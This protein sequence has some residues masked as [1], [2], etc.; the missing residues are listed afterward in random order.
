[1]EEVQTWFTDACEYYEA[2][3]VE[4]CVECVVAAEALLLDVIASTM[5]EPS[6]L[7]VL[8][9][10]YVSLLCLHARCLFELSPGTALSLLL[11]ARRIHS[12]HA[13]VYV[14]LGAFFEYHRLFSSAQECFARATAITNDQHCVSSRWF[15]V[16]F[17]GISSQDAQSMRMASEAVRFAMPFTAKEMIHRLQ[18]RRT[19]GDLYAFRSLENACLFQPIVLEGGVPLGLHATSSV[20]RS[21]QL[22]STASVRYMKREFLTDDAYEDIRRQS[23]IL[24]SHTLTPD[25]CEQMIVLHAFRWSDSALTEDLFPKRGTFRSWSLD[26]IFYSIRYL[27]SLK[28]LTANKEALSRCRA[29]LRDLPAGT[30]REA[31]SLLLMR[32]YMQSGDLDPV[33]DWMLSAEET[34]AYETAE[35]RMLRLFYNAKLQFL[36]GRFVELRDRV[37]HLLAEWI[38]HDPW[39][40]LKTVRM[41]LRAVTAKAQHDLV[42]YIAVRI[43]RLPD[44]SFGLFPTADF[45]RAFASFRFIRADH[46]LNHFLSMTLALSAAAAAATDS[47]TLLDMSVVKT[48]AD[49]I[50]LT[51]SKNPQ[52]ESD[53][54]FPIF[55]EFYRDFNRLM[56]LQS[57]N[58]DLVERTVQLLRRM[59]WSQDRSSLL[60]LHE[61][62]TISLDKVQLQRR[63]AAS[64]ILSRLDRPRHADHA[65]HPHPDWFIPFLLSV[66]LLLESGSNV[67]AGSIQSVGDVEKWASTASQEAFLG[68]LTIIKNTR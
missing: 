10:L 61:N 38:S 32:L 29:V 26:R 67:F 1:M 49:K 40:L 59:G 18:H 21:L 43:W 62:A 27:K 41:L 23:H 2:G 37:S 13:L 5:S 14:C 33:R 9:D 63:T 64:Y 46:I 39:L 50:T 12:S 20:R 31:F 15:S 54:R 56:K 51:L 68:L 25:L 48:F 66:K 53:P 3:L 22:L 17:R 8:N 7:S 58:D 52:F 57:S 45:T 34:A 11:H 19:Y 44:G 42:S 28:N 24:L 35:S 30:A 36:T 4:D 47:P 16:G 60:P 6:I 65:D 55:Y